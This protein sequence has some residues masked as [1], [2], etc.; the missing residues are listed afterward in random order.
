M[1]SFFFASLAASLLAATAAH[2][3][4]PAA[5]GASKPP[6]RPA[7][8]EPPI[9]ARRFVLSNLLGFRYNPLGFEDQLRAGFQQKLYESNRPAL[10][11]NFFFGGIFPK[12]NPAFT[13]VGPSIEIQPLSVF[14]LRVAAEFIGYYSTFGFLQSFRSPLDDFSDSALKRG[15]DAKRNYAAYGLHVMIEPAVQFRFGPIVLRDKF[16]IEHWRVKL[17]AGDRVF[18]DVTLDTA[19]SSIG[20]VMQN[21]LDLLY[22]HDFKSFTGKMKGAR[23]AAG[24]RYTTVQPFYDA[25][26]F[27][28]GDNKDLADNGHHRLGPLAA[29]TFFD[30]GYSRFNRPTAVVIANWYLDHRFRTGKDVSGAIP[31]MIVGFTFQSDLL[32]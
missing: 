5:A 3:Q 22:L 9:P 18:Y 28:P 20:W 6:T 17:N 1:R 11:D 2:A 4:A 25:D 29:F 15:K 26:D 24:V 12:V 30:D 16:A 7:D 19:V 13:K 31:Y 21:D 32:Q 10:R 27:A 23:I 14:N 8:D